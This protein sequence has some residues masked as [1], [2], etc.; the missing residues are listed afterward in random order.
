MNE[1]HARLC[2]SPEWA[3]MIQGELLPSL[4]E[5]V[6]LGS[7]MLEVGPGPG[8]ATDWLRSRVDHLVVLEIDPQA[9]GELAT[10]HSASNLD[11][12]VGDGSAMEFPDA[13]FDSVGC[14]TML[15]HVATA[16]VQAKVI[17]E[18]FRVLRPGG[19]LIA[20]DSL[21]SSELHHFHA[22]D[23]YNPVDPACLL[24]LA[25]A[26]GFSKM[27]LRVDA[28]LSLV[29]HKPV[30]QP[31]DEALLPAFAITK[32]DREGSSKP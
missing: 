18:M 32:P 31:G 28:V 30:A 11:V 22:G 3:E 27:N 21:A 6:E 5:G 16:T 13:S 25:R 26:L 9:A 10:K 24:V 17:S 4:V 23:C 14:F 29:A 20:S 12:V 15:H 7:D 8:A 2:S 1:N 19:V